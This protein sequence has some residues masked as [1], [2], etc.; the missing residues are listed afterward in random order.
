MI[1]ESTARSRPVVSAATNG[2]VILLSVEVTHHALARI[3][4]ALGPRR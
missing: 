4:D 2:C 3:E 1:S